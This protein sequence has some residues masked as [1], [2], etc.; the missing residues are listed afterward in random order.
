MIMES[1]G[2]EIDPA[3]FHEDA[4]LYLAVRADGFAGPRYELMREQLWTYAVNALAGMMRSGVIGERCPRAGLWHTEVEMLRRNRDL[5]DQLSLDTVIGA[6]ASWFNGEYGLRSW[7]PGKKAGLRTYFMGSLLSFELPNVMRRWRNTRL[8]EE[9]IAASLIPL[10]RGVDG[11]DAVVLRDVLRQV[12][13]EATLTQKGICGLIFTEDLTH[14]EIGERLGGK[15]AAAVAAQLRRLRVTAS[16]LVR[17]GRLDVP[18]GYLG[19]FGAVEDG[20]V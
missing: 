13:E 6:D 8:R 2:I 12:L 20:G 19:G 1:R 16:A 17:S 4:E 11:L 5:R 7:D 3:S 10:G 9:A 15:S 14:K 18:A